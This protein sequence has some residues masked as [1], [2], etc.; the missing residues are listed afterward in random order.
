VISGGRIDFLRFSKGWLLTFNGSRAHLASFDGKA[1]TAP[2]GW[3]TERVKIDGLGPIAFHAGD[4]TR[5]KRCE[6]AA[7]PA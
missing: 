5:C 1:L 2:C 3:R 7:R 4:Y 6:R